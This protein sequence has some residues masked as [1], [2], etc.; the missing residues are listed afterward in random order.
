[1]LRCQGTAGSLPGHTESRNPSHSRPIAG[2]ARSRARFTAHPL[3][4]PSASRPSVSQRDLH[5]TGP[6]NGAQVPGELPGAQGAPVLLT[7]AHLRPSSLGDGLLPPD[8]EQRADSTGSA[9]PPCAAGSVRSWLRPPPAPPTAGSAPQRPC[10]KAKSHA[11]APQ[12]ARK[13]TRCVQVRLRPPVTCSLATHMRS[14][15]VCACALCGNSLRRACTAAGVPGPRR[16]SGRLRVAH[17]RFPS[18]YRAVRLEPVPSPSV[19]ARN[20][21]P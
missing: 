17:A 6:R 13:R 11:D 12:A 5:R 10:A 21:P 4:R 15:A 16:R 14:A 19:P 18:A 20:H 8:K 2:G 1:M 3:S 9:R 7:T